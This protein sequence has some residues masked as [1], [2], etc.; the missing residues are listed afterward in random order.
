MSTLF[1]AEKEAHRAGVSVAQLREL[2]GYVRQQYGSDEMLAELRVLRTLRAIERGAI[3]AASAI[4]EFRDSPVII[5]LD[6]GLARAQL[7]DEERAQ[8]RRFVQTE[9]SSDERLVLILYY[10]ER[11]AFAEIAGDLQ[12]SEGEVE[13]IH[14]RVIERLRRALDPSVVT[15][16]F[17]IAS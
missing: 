7:A 16:A 9:L 6:A 3:S 12:V 13:R 14:A 17:R 15:R 2:E 5:E 4:Q 10:Y 11:R 1:D 8:V